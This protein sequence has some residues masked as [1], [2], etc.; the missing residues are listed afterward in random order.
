MSGE[1]GYADGA[2]SEVLLALKA[3]EDISA[4]STEL[5]AKVDSWETAYHFSPQRLGLLAPLRLRPELR[6]VDL[7]CGTGVLTRALGEAGLDVLGIEGTEDRAAA[8]RER[9]R[10]LPNV[11]IVRGEIEGELAAVSGMDLAVLCGVLE[12]STR[13]GAGPERLLAGVRKALSDRGVVALAI[14]N[15]LG[16]G[17][18]LGR[19]EDHHGKSWVGVA[20]YPGAQPQARTWTRRK[21]ASLLA[22]AGLKAQRWLLPYPDYKL[23]RV[24]LNTALFDRPDAPELVEKLVRDP[25]R[26]AF[27]GGRMAAPV[28]ELYRAAVAEG[29][30]V[31]VAP[32][33]LVL[34]SASEEPLDELL[35]PSL[36]WLVSA[37]RRPEWRRTRGLGRDLVLTSGTARS[38]KR[39]WLRQQTVLTESWLA[40]RPLDAWLL[41]AL[42]VGDLAECRR[43]AALWQRT[44]LAEAR[45][46]AADDELHPY[47][48]GREG[49]A[50]LPPDHLD[51]HPGN[52]IITPN[53]RVGRVDREW[54]A[55]TGV[56]AELAQLRSLLE[57]ANDLYDS[58]APHVW[59]DAATVRD[60]TRGLAGL[61]GLEAVADERWTE[62]VEA[63]GV[64]QWLVAGTSAA[65]T[66]KALHERASRPRPEPLWS[67]EGGL[68][69]LVAERDHRKRVEQSLRDVTADLERHRQV[70]LD[71]TA[72]LE[73][74]RQALADAHAHAEDLGGRLGISEQELSVARAEAARLDRRLGLVF[75][76][77]A[78][79]ALE[80]E[81][82][83]ARAAELEQQAAQVADRLSKTRARLDALEN[84]KIVRAAHRYL[85]PSARIARG[86]RDIALGRAGD[87]GDAVLRR[88]GP[89]AGVFGA[90]MR[91]SARPKREAELLYLVNVPEKPV[92]VGRGQVV[93]LDG[94]VVNAGIAV[95]DVRV[96][97]EGTWHV[98]SLGHSRPDVVAALGPSVVRT[99]E[100]CGFRVRLPLSP[101]AAPVDKPLALGVLLVDG[102]LLRREL[103][104]L[105]LVPSNL[106]PVTVSWPGSGPKV[107]VCM[108]TY[109]PDPAFL[110]AQLDSIKAQTHD[111]WVC[112]LSDDNSGPESVA[113]IRRLITG[114]D[115]FV[116]VA[117]EDN[118]GFY[119][120]FERALA[121][122]PSDADAVALADQDDVWDPD[123]LAT[124]LA[125][126]EGHGLAYSD[127]RLVDEDDTVVAGSF[128]QDRRNQWTDLEALLLLNTVTGASS[129]VDGR[130]LRELVL[131]FPPGT[132][133]AFHDQWTAAVALADSKLAFVDRALYSYRQ[134]GQ[135]VTGHRQERL[136]KGLP[137]RIGMALLALGRNEVL[138]AEQEAQLE[139]VAEYE[140]RRV[141]Q[142][143]TT[144]LLRVDGMT[145]EDRERLTELSEVEN[146]RAPLLKLAARAREETAG[147]ERFLLS[148]ALRWHALRRS[149]AKIPPLVPPSID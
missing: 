53:G 101:V 78:D 99:P 47:L 49:V 12:Y 118:V 14:E 19:P 33:F 88:S 131:P 32:S 97:F 56:D 102:T 116:L 115:R 10:D 107:A 74:H 48:P 127:M 66:V 44:V 103:P 112:V 68:D 71:V 119:A 25:L 124:L 31:E 104:P 120:N 3:A 96:L 9:C 121:A 67:V 95:K 34:A 76:E 57:F 84:A 58:G 59:G 128:W 4:G 39:D 89:L 61:V 60:L 28:R 125:A 142:F 43:L 135:A 85:W 13:F 109:R 81:W 122:A 92:A 79:A 42:R 146:R 52:L 75:A 40:G 63:E 147:A 94:W 41:D 69:G 136:D 83:Q 141:A 23:P 62:L 80:A 50:V 26:G 149:R 91:E 86:M 105:R 20:D 138:T 113:V 148:A 2:E 117:H 137:G 11:R 134:H 51:V 143:A 110:A 130:T 139:A 6:A 5:A 145:A 46:L 27:G 82:S 77:L 29:F 144:L 106:D 70:L 132:P 22:D 15:Q 126:L 72:D 87:E 64:L 129:L 17:Y 8:A 37:G 21:L 36:A 30:G 133:S 100:G 1:I 98:A 108:A 35:D 38:S 114:D 7:G 73:R 140:L 123:K 54:L 55:G 16:V 24:V 93:D 111:N 45:P 90:R 65:A 18:L